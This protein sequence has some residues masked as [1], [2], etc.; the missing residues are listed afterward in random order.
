M[1]FS[2]LKRFGV[3]VTVLSLLASMARAEGKQDFVLHNKTGVEIHN[4]FVSPHNADDWQEDVL[5]RDTLADDE[6][7]KIGFNPRERSAFWD[8]R[9]TDSEGH[10]IIWEKLNLLEISDVTIHY[11]AA[12][13]KV[14][15]EFAAPEPQESANQDFTLVNKTGVE[16]H[17][18]FVSPHSADEWQ[19][20]VLGRDTLA[21]GDS[22]KI[23]FNVRERA[24]L[25]DLK[26]TDSDGNSIVWEKF[27]LLKI[28]EITLHYDAESGKAT[29]EFE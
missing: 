9:V 12:T 29:A 7:V 6:S 14:T 27:N 25:W 26:V 8:L 22:V 2:F 21:D 1:S 18:L 4:L 28:S 20:D 23:G 17:N 10:S 5:G 3:L 16:I 19:E 24:A 13:G 15:A 11:D